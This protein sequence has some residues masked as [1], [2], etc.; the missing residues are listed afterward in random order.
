M[1]RKKTRKEIATHAAITR[2]ARIGKK[3]RSAILSKIAKKGA[4][5]RWDKARSLSTG[6]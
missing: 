4:K 5:A 1:V 3:E 2:W 6:E